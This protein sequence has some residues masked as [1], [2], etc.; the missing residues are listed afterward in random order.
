MRQEILLEAAA[1]RSPLCPAARWRHLEGDTLKERPCE[2]RLVL[3]SQVFSVLG[4]VQPPLE[5]EEEKGPVSFPIFFTP[6]F[7]GELLKE[8]GQL[9]HSPFNRHDGHKIFM[10]QQISGSL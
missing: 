4:S 7:P 9:S 3:P 5:L 1:G 6:F 8:Q 10:T 2:L